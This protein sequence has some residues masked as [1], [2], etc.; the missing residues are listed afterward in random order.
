M[1]NSAIG[2]VLFQIHDESLHSLLPLSIVQTQDDIETLHSKHFYCAFTYSEFQ[3]AFPTVD[4]ACIFLSAGIDKMYYWDRENLILFPICLNGKEYLS[5]VGRTLDDDISRFVSNSTA[6]LNDGNI[7]MLVAADRMKMEYLQTILESGKIA[8]D[9]LYDTFID[10]YTTSDYGIRYF[11]RDVIQSV[12][13]NK[14]I[15]AKNATRAALSDMPDT[16]VVYRG[17]GSQSANFEE[18]C[19][20]TLD[21]NVANFFACRRGLSGSRILVGQINKSDVIEYISEEKEIIISPS[22]VLLKEEIPLYGYSDMDAQIEDIAP[23]YQKYRDF[24]SQCVTFKRR[25][26][27]HGKEHC[28]RVL[29]LALTIGKFEGL[30]SKDIDT[31]ALAA[32]YHD[33]QRVTDDEDDTH[34]MDVL[35]KHPHLYRENYIAS[36]LIHYHCLPD[37]IGRGFIENHWRGNQ[38]KIDH[39]IKLFNIFKDAD[40]LDR[41][42]F[43]IR[44]VNLNMLRLPVSKRMT[45]LARLACENIKI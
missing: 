37:E 12:F 25:L 44:H 16:L 20:W 38:K 7:L 45:L 26:Y 27:E 23:M 22:S 34:G 8:T 18:A 42:R 2:E 32:V 36:V 41:V 19:S 11:S 6:N 9:K 33:C 15:A 28:G 24:L 29:L 39:I 21:I 14:P 1:S 3:T 43:G 30:S 13:E 5:P 40:A 10:F 4:T 31:L 17:E 35:K